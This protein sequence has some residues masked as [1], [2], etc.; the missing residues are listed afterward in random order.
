MAELPQFLRLEP[1]ELPHDTLSASTYL[2]FTPKILAAG[3]QAGC[4]PAEIKNYLQSHKRETVEDKISD[5]I[6][7]HHSVIFHAVKRNLLDIVELLLEYGADPCAKDPNNIPLLAATIMWT[8]WT[9]KNADKMVALL[10]SYGAD[11]RC[12]PENMWSTYIQMPT[13]D[14]NKDSSPHPSATWVK[15]QHRLILVETLNLTIRY[16]LNRA[17]LTKLAT[18]RQR[19]LAQLSGCPRILHLPF[20]IIGQDH[21]LEAVMNKIM[22]YDT[23]HRKRPLVLSFA[24][25]SGHGKTELATS[26]GSLLGTDICNVDMS[27]THTVMSLFGAAAG[28]QRSLGGS[29]LN[30]YLAS[31]GGQRCVIFLDEFDKTKQEVRESLL[32]ILD[33]GIGMD[34]RSNTVLDVTKSIWVLAS[35][36]GD[37]LISKFY[38]KNLKG[39]SDSEKR[40]VSIKPLQHDLYKLFIEAYTPAVTGRI[41]SFLPFF[42]FSRDEA[43][44][45]NHKFL[46]TLGD[47]V[48]LPIDL[49]SRPPRPVGHVHLSLLRDGDLCKFL[50]EDYIRELGAR[51]IQNRVDGLADDLFMLYKDSKKE[52]T[53]A[54]NSGPHIKYTLQLHPV[55]DT[56]EAAIREDGTTFIPSN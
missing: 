25:L 52:V 36:K 9:Y 51:S 15:K 11:P 54:T 6:Q 23:M 41:S 46:R 35:N 47:D 7:G 20:H 45:I 19:Q 31:H 33:T 1:F 18:A 8:K 28:Y 49:H 24:G 38:D 40:H 16:H 4:T 39:K 10:L 43:A 37:D 26:L 34:L 17:S 29:P 53:E 21:A 44:V 13:A 14:H 56:F 12:I 2:F 42:P 5:T 32:T 48:V 50:A 22:A 55:A 27:K 30:N 3:I